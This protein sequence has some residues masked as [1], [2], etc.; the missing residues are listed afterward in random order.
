MNTLQSVNIWLAVFDM[1]GTLPLNSIKLLFCTLIYS[2]LIK[3]CPLFDDYTVMQSFYLQSF[4]FFL[5][6]SYISSLPSCCLQIS[7]VILST[8][9]QRVWATLTFWFR[10]SFCLKIPEH[11]FESKFGLFFKCVVKLWNCIIEKDF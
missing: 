7:S 2:C 1:L 11:F 10:S 9:A 6:I 8:E 4:F 3:T 5:N